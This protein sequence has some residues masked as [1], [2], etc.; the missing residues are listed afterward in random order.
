MP[1]P[2]QRSSRRWL[3]ASPEQFD[4][5]KHPLG[6]LISSGVQPKVVMYRTPYCPYCTMAERL[7]SQKGI[8]F[9]EVDVSSDPER[10]RWLVTATGQRTVPQIF[11][12]GRSIGGFQELSGIARRGELEGLLAAAPAAALT[13]DPE[14]SA[15][16]QG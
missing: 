15:Q 2:I 16:T 11:I 3:P 1:S 8:P 5:W 10:R 13:D 4:P 7:L 12:N 6:V 9:T 14:G